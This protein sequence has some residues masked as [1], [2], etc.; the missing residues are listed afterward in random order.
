MSIHEPSAP[1]RFA[2]SA[3]V[4]PEFDEQKPRPSGS[5]SRFGAPFC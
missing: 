5:S 4:E 2:A 1:L 3:L